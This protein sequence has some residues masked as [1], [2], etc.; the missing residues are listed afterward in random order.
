VITR[1]SI[2]SY[3]NKAPGSQQ[4]DVTTGTSSPGYHWHITGPAMDIKQSLCVNP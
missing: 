1:I 3:G 4:I 2:N